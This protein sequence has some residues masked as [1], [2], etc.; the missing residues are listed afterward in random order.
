MANLKSTPWELAPWSHTISLTAQ[1]GSEATVSLLWECKA[2][3]EGKRECH[4]QP[5]SSNR[6]TAAHSS[7]KQT[8]VIRMKEQ[9][10]ENFCATHAHRFISFALGC[11]LSNHGQHHYGRNSNGGISPRSGAVKIRA[12]QTYR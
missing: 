2:L 5:S 7:N 10:H 3:I 11:W 8:V 9:N 6:W 4:R 12:R 1:R